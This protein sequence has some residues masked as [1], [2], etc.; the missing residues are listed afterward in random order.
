MDYLVNEALLEW[1]IYNLNPA[2]DNYMAEKEMM[3]AIEYIMK[4]IMIEMTDIKKEKLSVGYPMDTDDHMLESI[5][6]KAKLVV[7]NY[8]IKQNTQAPEEPLKNIN[9]F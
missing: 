4:K 7:L 9:A 1:Q 8:A 6:S 2:T 3:D 5:K